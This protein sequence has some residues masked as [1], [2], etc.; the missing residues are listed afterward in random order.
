[1]K[2]LL[3]LFFLCLG[4]SS[5][6]QLYQAPVY[7]ATSLQPAQS[8]AEVIYA[9]DGNPAT[10]Y[11]SKWNQSGI[12]DELTF[13][14]RSG[15]KNIKNIV[16]TPRTSGTNGIWT[17]VSV[18][19]STQS[20]PNT[21]IS[22]RENLTWSANSQDKEINL[23][24]AVANPYAIKFKVSAGVGDLS[25]CA[26]MKFY[27]SL[28][29]A[30][31]NDTPPYCAIPTATLT[32]DTKV[33]V[34]AAGSTASSYQGSENIDKSFD[35]NLS[36]IYHS[37]Y[38]NNTQ[39]PV[40]LN[41]R[42]NGTTPIDYLI[43]IPRT[44]GDNGNFGKVTI[45]YNTSSNAT[46]QPLTSVDF[47]QTGQT[48]MVQFPSRIT[49]LNIRLS[50][51]D[52][53]NNYASCAEMEFY[54]ST[55]ASTLPYSNIF[56]DNLYSTLQPTVTQADI[57]A[58][59]SPFYKALAQCIF[60]DTYVAKYRVQTYQV[61]LP[62]ATIQNQLKT[63]QYSYYENPTGIVF[64]QGEKVALFARNIPA[65]A[66][67]NLLVKNF[68][69]ELD[70]ASSSYPLRNGL[71]TF[72][73][74][75]EGLGYIQYYNDNLALANVDVN[76]VSGKINGY[77]KKGV[78]SDTEWSSLLL[79]SNYPMLDLQGTNT[80]LVYRKDALLTG[81]PSEPTRLMNKYD[82]I[83]AH[84]R[85]QM[86]LYKYNRDVKN[87]NFA[88]SNHGGG[89]YAGG[90]GV[91]LDID[92]G[93][94]DLT[95]PDRLG[96]WGIAHEFGHINQVRPDLKWIGLAEVTNNI[97]SAWVQYHMRNQSQSTL[98][99]EHES[100]SPVTGMTSISGGRINGSLYN[101]QVQGEAL[102]GNASPDPFKV[103]VPFW[104]LELYYQLAGASRNAP[105]LS[106]DYPKD[107]TGTDYA[108]WHGT[109][110]EM[111]RNTNSESLKSGEL[112]L[113]FVKNTCDVVK[114]DLTDF[115]QSTGF[116]RPINRSIDD[117]GVEQLTV[118]QAQ[119][120]AAI[121]S[122]KS[123]GYPAPVSPVIKYIS[124][125]SLQMFK[126][127]LPIS[128]QTGLGVAL[129][130]NYLTVQHSQWKNAIVYETYDNTGKLIF[131]SISG[132]G[133]ISNQTT[134]V[135]YPATA[136]SV[137]AVGFDGKKILVYPATANQLP[138]VNI[139]S[140]TNDATFTAPANITINATATDADGSITKVE[141][142]NGTTLLGEDLISPYNYNWSGVPA[143]SYIL[144]A[145][146]YD[147]TGAVNSSSQVSITVNTTA[148]P[149][150][151]YGN[152]TKTYGDAAFSMAATSTSSGAFTYS[153]TS[154][155]SLATINATTGLVTIKGAGVVTVK[156]DQAAAGTFNAGSVNATLTISK[157][158]LTVKADNKTKVYNTANPAF[159]VTYTGFAY[160]DN[161]A[162]LNTQAS[163]ST[164]AVTN[165]NV[166]NYA[167]SASGAISSNYTFNYAAGD[168]AITPASPNGNIV[169]TNSTSG[170]EG[171][172]ITINASVSPSSGTVT[173]TVINGTGTATISE[174]QLSLLTSGTVTVVAN[175][176]ASGNYTSGSATQIITIIANVAPI[177]S[178]ISPTNNASF[179]AP[180]TINIVADANDSD[181]KVSKVE[182]FNGDTKL[183]EATTSPYSYNW[184]NVDPDTYT[185]TAIATDN[186]G[187]ST[188]SS[189]ITINVSITTGLADNTLNQDL[190]VYPNPTT[191][192]INVSNSIVAIEV[193]D[194]T[195]KILSHINIDDSKQADIS[196]L[197]SGTYILKVKSPSTE[198][199]VKIIKE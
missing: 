7:S 86:G 12:P 103:L 46:Y 62:N 11:H 76:I 1:M 53:K 66:S 130:N 133:D 117:Y 16:Y 33:A 15:V 101:T 150:I 153:I 54:T 94:E 141:F 124:A 68:K 49:P 167:I 71:N 61:Y 36:T 199:F 44:S 154:G 120:N 174:N 63:A 129:N 183:G 115:F 9:F 194:L 83:I 5:Y 163:A 127:K 168:L 106:F 84:E 50:V 58:I 6:A 137:Y 128:G 166:G 184:T 97:H 22:L 43:Y 107:Y 123:K 188:R 164:T 90:G 178:I 151:T 48:T 56:A 121:A 21:F 172:N 23:T 67:V 31:I 190:S 88:Y 146:A 157:K 192:T 119:I 19:Y 87:H 4:L 148:A 102:Q 72:T 152:V 98:R 39:F 79:N 8:G 159:T 169:F 37:A 92:W 149:E 108:H 26:E 187:A 179:T 170:R 156:V 30:T 158:T 135:Y 142:Y 176:T 38:G 180:V 116:L 105:V 110:A 198:R 60:N 112:L 138:V 64:E 189:A 77:F 52:G 144:T 196:D 193:F 35:N 111:A 197:A 57:N 118:T 40:L 65:G 100:V 70:G 47:G 114:E 27:S 147:N 20:A 32:G 140:P 89:W 185:I 145:K 93:I 25:S 45:S 165:S 74:S 173:Y 24:N 14:F 195:G 139:T 175:V 162:S 3:V 10:T 126:N 96:L 160:S 177:V 75:N 109:L 34:I 18:Y 2:K 186:S 182:F 51:Q 134:R 122:I 99:L 69:T 143:G 104:Q 171:T 55:P 59:T 161:A 181:G 91:N 82:T 28:P 95:H 42:F 125:S 80:H 136:R 73:V 131:V 81:C 85:L 155:N 191:G 17:N 41:Y 113:N 132:T 13:Y 78:T 29:I